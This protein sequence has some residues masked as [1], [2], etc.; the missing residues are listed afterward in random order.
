MRLKPRPRHPSE[1]KTDSV[2][3]YGASPCFFLLSLSLSLFSSHPFIHRLVI[4]FFCRCL[5]NSCCLPDLY[6]VTGLGCH[7]SSGLPDFNGSAPHSSRGVSTTPGSEL[8]VL[9]IYGHFTRSF[10]AAAKTE[11]LRPS[12]TFPAPWAPSLPLVPDLR[13]FSQ[14]KKEGLDGP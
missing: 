2:R 1:N 3:N 12:S 7:F 4:N 11:T 13:G 5:S 10:A 9:F 8:H 14:R 6:K